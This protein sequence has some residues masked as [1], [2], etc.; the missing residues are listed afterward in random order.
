MVNKYILTILN[1]DKFNKEAFNQLRG[2]SASYHSV[3]LRFGGPKLYINDEDR[4]IEQGI[5]KLSKTYEHWTGYI[6]CD[7]YDIEKVRESITMYLVLRKKGYP[8]YFRDYEEVYKKVIKD[9]A[10]STIIERIYLGYEEV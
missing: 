8:V 7:A 9:D 4:K 5:Y 6:C 10:S 1:S 2:F 3:E